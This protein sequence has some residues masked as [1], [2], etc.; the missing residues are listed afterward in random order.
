[1]LLDSSICAG[2]EERTA[3][4]A[5]PVMGSEAEIREEEAGGDEIGKVETAGEME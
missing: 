5:E 2:E 1:M 4:S 3:G